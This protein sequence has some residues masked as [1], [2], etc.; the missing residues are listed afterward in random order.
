L[1]NSSIESQDLR[2]RFRSSSARATSATH[3]PLFQ[4]SQS[5]AFCFGVNHVR[6]A[7]EYVDAG[8]F[9]EVAH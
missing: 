5:S 8:P 4:R 9:R 2:H 6:A 7:F 3:W 1:S